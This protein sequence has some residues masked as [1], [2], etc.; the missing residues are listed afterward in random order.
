MPDRLTPE[1]R[2]RCM[3]S[4]RSRNTKPEMMVRRYLFSRGFRYRVNVKRLPGTPDIVLRKYR[5]VIFINGCFWH[6]H[7]D[8]PYFV[9]PKTNTPFWKAK[10]ERNR[11]RDMQKRIQL[12]LLGW[13]TIILWECQ[14]KPK[15]REM[16]L[17]GLE[18]TL[19][20]IYLENYSL[21]KA[22]P[23]P[24]IEEETGT[25]IAADGGEVTTT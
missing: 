24:I 20:Q 6:G 7:E 14:L 23:Y 25:M 1:Q 22:R 4:I 11:E 17:K 3:K 12:R 2:H 8:C 5:T 21:H 9:L 13:H 15:Q 19:N 18:R 16:T 10:I